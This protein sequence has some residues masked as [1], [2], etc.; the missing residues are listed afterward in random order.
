MALCSLSTGRSVAPF[1]LGSRGHQFA[2]RDERFLVCEGHGPSRLDCSH[3][4]LEP[5]TSDDCRHDQVGIESGSFDEGAGPAAARQPVPPSASLSS[6][7]PTLVGNH[8]ELCVRPARDLGERID[9][10][11]G[12]QCLN[13]ELL[14]ASARS[15]RA[16][17]CRSSR[18]SEDRDLLHARPI[19]WAAKVSTATGTRPSRRSRSPP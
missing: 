18:G 13:L 8:S 19:A 3:C 2:C 9:V 1:A 5:G 12:R 14:R 16:S 7:E 10:H 17:I 11:R 6:R 4:R 15:D